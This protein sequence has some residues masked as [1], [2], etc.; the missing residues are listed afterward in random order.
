MVVMPQRRLLAWFAG[1][2]LTLL[3]AYSNHFANGFHFDDSHTVQFNPAIR[4]LTNLP[5][6]FTDS[7]TFS[8]KPAG[9]RPLVTTS[10][11][12]DYAL[13]RGLEPFWFHLSTFCWF[14]V[15]LVLVYAL[16]LV[17]FERTSPNPSNAWLAWLAAAIYGLHPVSAETVNYIVQRG[18]LY[19]TLGIVA[20]VVLYARKSYRWYFLP[21]LAGMLAKPTALVFAPILLAYI[22]LIER[23]TKSYV[24]R[25]LPAF[26]LS[27]LLAYIQKL[28]LPT[29]FV[30]TTLSSFDYWITQPY[31][32]LRYFRSFFLPLYLSADTDLRAFDS[33]RSWQV[34]VGCL[35][36]GMLLAAAI[37]TARR[38]EWRPVSFGLW[39]YFIGLIPTAVFP[40]AEVENDHRMFLPF[41][42]LSLAVVWTIALLLRRPAV[43]PRLRLAAAGLSLAVLTALAWGTHQRN[44]VWRTEET[45]WHDV[46]EKSPS[47]ARGLLNYGFALLG[48]GQAGPAYDYYQRAAVI[49]PNY[50]RLEEN[51]GIAAGALCRDQEAEAH[52]R[53][54]IQLSP[55]DPWSYIDYAG[56]LLPRGKIELAL[57]AYQIAAKLNAPNLDARYGLMEI[58]S[59]QADWDNLRFIVNEALL[60]APGDPLTLSYAAFAQNPKSPIQPGKPTSQDLL[61]LSLIYRQTGRFEDSI[62]AAHKVLEREPDSA[63]AYIEM[64]GA[65]QA[66][67]RWDE[68]IAASRQALRLR[69]SFAFALKDLTWGLSRK[70]CQKQAQFFQPADHRAVTLSGIPTIAVK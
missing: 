69:P 27:G 19:A 14:L 54:A 6:F 4:S 2:F 1:L 10:L 22:I 24:R 36:C 60:L 21:P 62:R 43:S 17:V 42:G 25:S 31:V 40:L 23:D 39:W 53:S 34:L 3:A 26:A 49:K 12:L 45:L 5:R 37:Y 47:N 57:R 67:E 56:W 16:C 55:Y 50:F 63:E 68:A 61:N 13:G 9:Y 20:G 15:Q 28:M 32:T 29:G 48:N 35:F 33:F 38:P 58:Y 41:V 30:G 51:I 59:R 46:T 18:D 11:A 65:D 64:S 44:E 70:A 7:S 52:F 8:I 66:L